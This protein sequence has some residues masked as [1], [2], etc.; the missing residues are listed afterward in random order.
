MNF[1]IFFIISSAAGQR[2]SFI[3][4]LVNQIKSSP[5]VK[6]ASPS[7]NG[8][9]K[10]DVIG[11]GEL[12]LQSDIERSESGSVLRP[13]NINKAPSINDVI[14]GSI[15]RFE[16]SSDAITRGETGETD[17]AGKDT[18]LPFLDNTST[19]AQLTDPDT[20][21]EQSQNEEQLMSQGSHSIT[22]P[23]GPRKFHDKPR[24]RNPNNAFRVRPH[25]GDM[26][27]QF[28]G[29]GKRP[30]R[31]KNQQKKR[32]TTDPDYY[33]ESNELD[34]IEVE[35]FFP[36]EDN[37]QPFAPG[38]GRK[39]QRPRGE[40][41]NNRP[42]RKQGNSQR[43]VNK[44]FKKLPVR[45]PLKHQNRIKDSNFRPPSTIYHGFAP[46]FKG[47]LSYDEARRQQE[48]EKYEIRVKQNER[49]DYPSK[50]T[51]RNPFNKEQKPG[52]LFEEIPS[53]G[54]PQENRPTRFGPDQP[55]RQ[56]PRPLEGE[57]TS[58]FSEARPSFGRPKEEN[59]KR[60]TPR[61]PSP[62]DDEKSTFGST[63]GNSRDRLNDQQRRPR[64]PQQDQSDI[65]PFSEEIP[66]FGPVQDR[67]SG[68][69]PD[70]P[71]RQRP[72]PSSESSEQNKF[73]SDVSPFNQEIPSF[74]PEPDRPT[75]FRPDR[76]KRQRPHQITDGLEVPSFNEEI[77][78]F[79]PAQDRPSRFRPDRPKRQRP[80]PITEDS[81]QHNFGLEVPGNSFKE[82][83][84]KDSPN[85]NMG[86]FN[87]V[88]ENFPDI[89][90]F[91]VGWDPQKVRRKRAALENPFYYKPE[92][93]RPRRGQ[94]PRQSTRQSNRRQGP[95]GFWDDADFDAEFFNGGS[96]QAFNSFD[97]FSQKGQNPFKTH[98]S[99][100]IDRPR[101]LRTARRPS[102]RPS[103]RVK[104]TPKKFV[105]SKYSTSSDNSYQSI[106]DNSILGSG[107][108][109]ILKGG[110]FY[111]E[112]DYRRPYSNNQQAQPYNFYGNKDIFHNFRDF[113]DIKDDNKQG[114][115]EGFYYR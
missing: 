12:P 50:S 3:Q 75:R 59:L 54:P 51:N 24:R 78:S 25:I 15:A 58:P 16:T 113:A 6:S 18:N 63:K 47:S 23:S 11:S 49:G 92:T 69:R 45:R 95:G 97:A 34:E 31:K 101:G 33:D 9:R 91:G 41:L 96:P 74:G 102:P 61:R 71:K 14:T 90:A 5:R 37:Q 13:I 85:D 27:T 40:Q 1:L 73:G 109:E 44:P 89:T 17:T 19:L 39:Q 77:P 52:P 83:I 55:R 99:Q 104:I 65:L 84:F 70:R 98:F 35:E 110:T 48:R 107:N 88:Q 105:S 79:G 76:P 42:K 80:H 10:F 4:D 81:E 100:P 115:D 108:F 8:E 114:Y 66:T 106:E 46:S 60:F 22:R 68:F 87:D 62:F 7:F 29:K 82:P 67:P 94:R 20:M 30:R 57:N 56:W 32:P 26:V 86:F 72:H 112:D 64:P 2:T 21:T 38:L 43:N 36:F 93:R 53:F 103:Q 111:D 28:L